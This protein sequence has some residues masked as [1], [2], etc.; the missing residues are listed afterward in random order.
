[1]VMN[2]CICVVDRVKAGVLVRPNNSVSRLTADG[3]RA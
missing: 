1:M 3:V 2:A